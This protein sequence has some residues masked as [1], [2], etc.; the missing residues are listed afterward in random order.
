MVTMKH[1]EG[2]V[3]FRSIAAAICGLLFSCAVQGSALASGPDLTC[4]SQ[5]D[6]YPSFACVVYEFQNG[7]RH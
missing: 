5:Q 3:P 4:S 2:A 1:R 7:A 6:L